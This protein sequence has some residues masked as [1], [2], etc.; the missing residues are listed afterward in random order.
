[1][2]T[3]E[4]KEE[5]EMAKRKAI[6]CMTGAEAQKVQDLVGGNSGARKEDNWDKSWLDSGVAVFIGSKGIVDGWNPIESAIRDGYEIIDFAAFMSTEKQQEDKMVKTTFET[7]HKVNG[8]N[9]DSMS[10]GDFLTAIASA[11][12]EIKVLKEMTTKSKAID[13]AVTDL[14]KSLMEIVKHFDAKFG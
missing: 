12:A 7:T 13:A 4:R 14:E 5:T 1:M 2:N 8:T 6:H 10:K 9:V 3:R 11:E